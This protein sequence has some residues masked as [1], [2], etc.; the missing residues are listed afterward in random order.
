M[1]RGPSRPASGI[2]KR[3]SI[4]GSSTT[5]PTAPHC[6][7]RWWTSACSSASPPVRPIG[8]LRGAS[9]DLALAA[10]T[11]LDWA[12]AKSCALWPTR[13]DTIQH[14]LD[15]V[16]PYNHGGHIGRP[17][18]THRRVAAPTVDHYLRMHPTEVVRA[19]AA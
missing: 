9:G 18:R 10:A 12:Y 11:R 1:W 19:R 3:M 14:R 8:G 16:R 6:G 2:V 7:G 17:G 4:Y 13:A 5:T 15:R